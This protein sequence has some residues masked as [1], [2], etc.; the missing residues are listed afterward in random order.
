MELISQHANTHISQLCS[1]E[2]NYC[3]ADD[4]HQKRA[5]II[6]MVSLKQQ[7]MDLLLT[8]FNKHAAWRALKDF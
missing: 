8:S 5:G 1:K 7:L 2:R 3:T 6:N 4:Q